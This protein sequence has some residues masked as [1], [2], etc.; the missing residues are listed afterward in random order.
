MFDYVRCKYPLPLS[1]YQD[2]VF[3]TKDTPAQYCDI[4]EIREDGTLWYETYD[5]EDRSDP[6]A[7]GFKRFLGCMTKVNR[8]WV[9]EPMTGEISFYDFPT[10]DHNDGGWVEFSAYFVNG[11]LREINLIE[12]SPPQG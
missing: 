3:Q 6:K 5:I 7:E 4:Y 10:G 2:R 1:E 9:A 8:R 12:N 11:K